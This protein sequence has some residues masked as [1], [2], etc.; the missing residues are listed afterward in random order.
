M[1]KS[2]KWYDVC[3]RFVDSKTGQI[4]EIVI[5]KVTNKRDAQKLHKAFNA[6][7]DGLLANR[8]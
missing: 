4:K 3:E 5:G 1:A 7:L 2:K 8:K 6:Y